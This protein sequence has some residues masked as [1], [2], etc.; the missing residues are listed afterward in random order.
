LE[1]TFVDFAESASVGEVLWH[2]VA[3]DLHDL[4]MAGI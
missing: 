2:V 1:S 4:G 3:D